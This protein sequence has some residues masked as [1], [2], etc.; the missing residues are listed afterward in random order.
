MHN[1]FAK[2][3]L[4]ICGP[5]AR[6]TTTGFLHP[7]PV[8]AVPP[9]RLT[10]TPQKG[11]GPTEVYLEL[12]D[13]GACATYGLP[14]VEQS[15]PLSTRAWIVQERFLSPRTLYFGTSQ[16]Y[17]ECRTERTW[18][19]IRTANVTVMDVD[20]RSKRDIHFTEDAKKN[21]DIW[22][23]L[24]E[25][26]SK[27]NLTNES[28]RLPALSGLASRMHHF[29]NLTY[30]AGLWDEDL[31]HG[32]HWHVVIWN[33][34]PFDPKSANI[35]LH[36]PPSWSWASCDREISFYSKGGRSKVDSQ[37]LRIIESLA[38]STDQ[39]PFGEVLSSR[40]VVHGRL[41]K[42][43]VRRRPQE[44]PDDFWIQHAGEPTTDFYIVT[45]ETNENEIAGLF[46]DDGSGEILKHCDTQCYEDIWCLLLG[47][48]HIPPVEGG[49]SDAL[50]FNVQTKYWTALALV[51][52]GSN[53]FRRVGFIVSRNFSD[54]A[55][56]GFGD[57]EQLSTASRLKR[58]A[59][60]WF[61]DSVAEEVSI[62]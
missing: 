28:D 58:E 2:S 48:H 11:S 44:K 59:E 57:P 37:D 46:I 33:G 9:C 8:S 51:P 1:T 41:K 13:P 21:L 55:S 61:Q 26:Y 12:V 39:N 27:R 22:Y 25:L 14:R 18:E 43:S 19:V 16:M 52:V 49:L 30:L 6:N 50:M 56:F 45:D 47:F 24:V 4:T 42:A 40:L 20:R 54:D 32:L 35:A 53:V 17:L 15:S 7:R 31:F 29:S 3:S 5:G 38:R 36:K 62:I 60:L 10:V 34:G 23:N